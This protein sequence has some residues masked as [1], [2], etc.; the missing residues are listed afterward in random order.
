MFKIDVRADIEKAKR[1]LDL[2]RHQVPPMAAK[3]INECMKKA[4]MAVKAEMVRV[5]D[6]PTPWTLKSYRILK[7]A[8][9]D[10]GQLFGVVGFKDTDYAGSPGYMG[11][12]PKPGQTKGGAGGTPASVYLQPQMES[13]PRPAKRLE[14]L[15]RQRGMLSGNEFLVPSQFMKLDEYG[16]VPRGVINQVIANLCVS[17]DPLG[18]TPSG[19]S[20]R[21]DGSGKRRQGVRQFTMFYFT[22]RGVRGARM[23]AIWQRFVRNHAQPAFIVVSASPKYRK[24]FDQQAVVQREVDKNFR[25]EFDIAYARAMATAR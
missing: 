3:A 23:T 7:Y 10:P 19:G 16:N 8:R 22:R 13:G 21:S 14:L 5:F 15:M 2:D 11:G 1:E 20:K 4:D 9:A 17:F 12:T 18:D 24:R 25:N 6:R